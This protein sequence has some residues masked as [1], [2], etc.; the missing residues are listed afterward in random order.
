[1]PVPERPW[2]IVGSDLFYFQGATYLL[3]IDYFSRFVEV[4]RLSSTTSEDII[5]HLKSM[6]SRHGIPEIFISDNGPQYASKYFDQFAK[7]YEF[8]HRT[9]SPRYP[10][11]NGEADRAVQT[12]KRL[13]RKNPKDPYKALLAYR[14][15][16]LANGYS[17]AELCFGRKIRTTIPIKRDLLNP[18]WPDIET[19]REKE[20]FLKDRQKENYDLRYRT[21]EQS[22][23]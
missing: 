22:K 4:A 23:L 18:R 1:M 11:S 20:A 7:E 12:V 14:S 8:Q 17:P 16:P 9:S 3:V 10:Q 19:V 5:V 21:K 15:T 2:Q 13:L 6:F